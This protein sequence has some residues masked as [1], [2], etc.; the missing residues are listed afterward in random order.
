MEGVAVSQR[1]RESKE[2]GTLA[3]RLIS[4]Y[5]VLLPFSHLFIHQL[6]SPEPQLAPVAQNP[7]TGATFGG[8]AAAPTTAFGT[9]KPISPTSGAT[10]APAGVFG[11][12]HLCFPFHHILFFFFF[13]FF[14]FLYVLLLFFCV[15]LLCPCYI[16]E[17]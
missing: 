15:C 4:F 5:N 17:V 14:F 6:Q 2:R 9:P 16:K 7:V 11:V 3:T 12:S 8:F 1:K 10:F 13:F